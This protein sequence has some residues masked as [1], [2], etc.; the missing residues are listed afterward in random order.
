MARLASR[1]RYDDEDYLG[2]IT[3]GIKTGM[4]IAQAYHN[5]ESAK[6]SKEFNNAQL[7]DFNRAEASRNS[8]YDLTEMKNKN[9][10]LVTEEQ[11][12]T[13]IG[14]ASSRLLGEAIRAKDP[15]EGIAMLERNLKDVSGGLIDVKFNP[16]SGPDGSAGGYAVDIMADGSKQTVNVKSL[17]EFGGMFDSMRKNAGFFTIGERDAVK[18]LETAQKLWDGLGEQR[19]AQYGSYEAFMKSPEVLDHID[20]MAS[21][22][23]SGAEARQTTKGWKQGDEKHEWAGESHRTQQQ[24]ERLRQNSIGLDM[25]RT[26]QGIGFDAEN[27]KYLVDVT[28]KYDERLKDAQLQNNEAA[29]YNILSEAI[30]VRFP[31]LQPTYV[32]TIAT[33]GIDGLGALGVGAG[34]QKRQYSDEQLAKKKYIIQIHDTLPQDMPL[35]QK[36]EVIDAKLAEK[37]KPEPEPEPSN[38]GN[39]DDG[40]KNPPSR[41]PN[42]DT[43]TS[44]SGKPVPQPYGGALGVN[45]PSANELAADS[46]RARESGAAFNE[47]LRT[48]TEGQHTRDQR[49]RDEEWRQRIGR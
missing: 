4:G 34:A 24:T 28:R 1:D 10:L 42:K 33:D 46:R 22:N 3:D 44:S 25:Q 35:E 26:R 39:K 12:K 36:W 23:L 47:G 19:Q 49:L 6:A 20:L 41:K 16:I 5:I 43:T 15:N 7:A 8:G 27:Q 13:I 48:L 11:G 14:T 21:N 18:R 32:S 45:P 2:N 30:E 29:F 37:S 9:E 40:K 17:Q 31:E 38:D